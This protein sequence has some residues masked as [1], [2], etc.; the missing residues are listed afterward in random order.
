VF[1]ARQHHLEELGGRCEIASLRDEHVDDLAVLVHGSVHVPP[2]G[3]TSE[4]SLID[5]PA[6]TDTVPARP[7]SLDD[8]WRETLHPPI[9]S[10][11]IDID[12]ALGEKFLDV[13]VRSS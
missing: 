1:A 3:P 9:D 8:E 12:A 2:H 7:R 10:D 11:V 13:S 5:E 6:V 4:V